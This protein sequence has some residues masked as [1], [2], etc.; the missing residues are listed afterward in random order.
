M[1]TYKIVCISLLCSVYTYGEARI[2]LG[3]I[4]SQRDLPSQNL[5]TT[6]KDYGGYLTLS[7][8]ISFFQRLK[9]GAITDIGMGSNTNNN[10]STFFDPSVKLGFNTSYSHN[11]LWI[12]VGFTGGAYR[13]D[14]TPNRIYTAYF[15]ASAGFEGRI[16]S[17]EK[18]Y[19]EYTADYDYILHDQISTKTPSIAITHTNNGN[20]GIRASI[21]FSYKLSENIFYYIK[22]RA[23]YQNLAYHQTL[24]TANN[25]I[26]MIEI[27]IGGKNW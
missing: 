6:S 16:Q 22:F 5:H 26:G 3:G 25:L 18:L 20:Y 24:P 17:G 14:I 2:G 9:L 8:D 19:Y 15:A 27:G 1:R 7:G 21:G 23:K 12:N 4:Y 13:Y 10:S 11:P